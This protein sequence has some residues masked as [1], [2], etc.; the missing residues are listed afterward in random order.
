MKVIHFFKTSDGARWGLEQVKV[1]IQNG[2]EV[3]VVLPHSSGKMIEKWKELNVTIEYGQFEIPLK[4][5]WLFARQKKALFE[6]LDKYRP[7]YLH[8]HFFSITVFLRH[9]LGENK[10]PIIFQVPGPLH[11]ENE[12][13]KSWDLWSA[14]PCDRWIASSHAIRN[15]Y[16]TSGIPAY[17]VMLSYYG[18]ELENYQTQ[19]EG[20]KEKYGFRSLD[21]IVGNLSYFYAP[22]LYLG[23]TK[24][25]KGHE[26]LFEAM[27]KIKNPN[28]KGLFFGKQWG[29]KSGYEKKLKSLL[30]KNSKMPGGV[31]PF[32][33]SHAWKSMDICVHIPFSE[34]C[35]GVLEPLLHSIPVLASNIG[36]LPEIVIHGKTGLICEREIDDIIEKIEWAKNH[37][38]EMSRMTELGK[39]LILRTFD[40]KRSALEVAKYYQNDLTYNEEEIFFP[41]REIE[42]L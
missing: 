5:P 2:I 25:L 37:P 1:L 12:I 14:R 36:G 35:G 11:L 41:W 10:T 6:L 8:S 20:N 9:A 23:Q 7:N 40:V 15:L 42:K 30:P 18:N 28:I 27:K 3:I 34:N 32:E 26:L 22:K 33:V 13:F 21:Y 16:L 24:G 39:K 19:G 29:N 4:K 38:Q 31:N 17:R